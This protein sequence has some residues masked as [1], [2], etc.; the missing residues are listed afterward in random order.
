MWKSS[1]TNKVFPMLIKRHTIKAYGEAE[2]YLHLDSRKK[3]G[4][5]NVVTGAHWIGGCVC[6]I[7]GLENM[8]IDSALVCTGNRVTIRQMS[9]QHP[10]PCTDCAI[11]DPLLR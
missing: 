6:P 10:S 8:E 2:V 4:W 3:C 11:P 1:Y 9:V 7:V 5:F